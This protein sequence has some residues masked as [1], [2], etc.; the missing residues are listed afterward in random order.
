[1]ALEGYKLE[2]W[3]KMEKKRLFY[4]DFVR[5]IAAISIVITH[6]NAV[7]L[8]AN[9]PV[10]NCYVIDANVFNIYIGGF[11][12]SLFLIISGAALMHVYGGQL[13]IKLFYWKRCKT[14]YPM[15]WIAYLVG[16]SYFYIIRKGWSA[17]TVPKWHILYSILGIDG[18]VAELTDTFYLLGEWFLGF[19]IIFYL[20]FPLLKGIMDKHPVILA[21][22]VV[23]IYVYFQCHYSMTISSSKNLF[24]RLP[25]LLFGMYFIKYIKKVRLPEVLCA[26]LV[27]ILN[28]FIKPQISEDIQTTY[29]G[30]AS[31]IV[32][33][34]VSYLLQ[35]SELVKCCCS[36]VSKYSYA[37]FLVHHIVI[38]YV[39]A[40][41]NLYTITHV[42]S[43]IM[44]FGFCVIIFVMSKVL[45]EVDKWV[46]NQ[47]SSVYN[48]WRLKNG[49]KRKDA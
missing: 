6:Y 12:V 28:T 36:W 4:L 11:G 25:E 26:L 9:P 18:Y 1:M 8:F 35:K 34:Y 40:T 21:I 32:L 45:F 44:F 33:V 42:Q 41:F 15:F 30:I 47:L 39:M 31:F 37:I 24:V 2:S 48:K 5:A 10:T 23:V 3:I 7:F 13:D 27:I 22:A 17:T 43:Y 29:I 38:Y 14:I 46:E 49:E 20:I 19:I 16:F